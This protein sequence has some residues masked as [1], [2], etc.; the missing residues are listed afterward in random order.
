MFLMFLASV[1]VDQKRLERQ[2]GKGCG[3]TSLSFAKNGM[4]A[5]EQIV[6]LAHNRFLNVM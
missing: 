2:H 6:E 1:G 4:K 5:L 3:D